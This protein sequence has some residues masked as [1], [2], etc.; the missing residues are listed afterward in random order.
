MKKI[1]LM[2]GNIALYLGIF[3]AVLFLLRATYQWEVTTGLA[4]F[5]DY[6]PAMF[7]GVLSA[8]ILLLYMLLFRLKKSIWPGQGQTLFQASRFKRISLKNTMFMFGMGLAGCL[9][10]IGLMEIDFIAR[11]FPSIPGL[12]ND[13][14]RSES[15]LFVILGVGLLGPIYEEILFRGLIYK[16]LRSVMP[17]IAAIIVQAA[18]YAYFQPSLSLSAIGLGSGIIYAILCIRLSSIWAP[19]IV[20][21]SAMSLIFIAKYVGFY[22]TLNKLGE[23]M[24]YVITI[25]SLLS[26]LA[27]TVYVWRSGNGE[28]RNPVQGKSIPTSGGL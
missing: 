21:T 15:I 3:Y 24:L 27:G 8:V 1:L 10:S 9:F 22:E 5:M 2:I 25:V 28:N 13:M 23:G 14:M 7:M 18:I 6:N 11:N 4:K 19:I 20:Q 26:L 12:V 16:H 17:M